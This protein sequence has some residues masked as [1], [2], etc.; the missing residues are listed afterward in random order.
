MQ[1][2]WITCPFFEV[3]CKFQHKEAEKENDEEEVKEVQ[4]QEQEEPENN[5]CYLCDLIFA[6]QGEL[7][8]HMGDVH[9]DRFEHIQ[10]A[11]SLITFLWMTKMMNMVSHMPN[12]AGL[13]I[14]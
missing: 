4:S 9:L 14:L 11:N 10:Q 13:V 12:V 5:F 3:G 1:I 6:T 8:T 7:I 2:L